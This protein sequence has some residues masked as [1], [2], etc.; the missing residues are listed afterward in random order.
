LQVLPA[1]TAMLVLA[2]AMAAG[3]IC[4]GERRELWLAR[5]PQ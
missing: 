3:I 1:S 2:A 5:W 4:C